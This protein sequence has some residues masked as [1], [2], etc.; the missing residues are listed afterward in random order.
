M[1]ARAGTA[2]LCATGPRGRVRRRLSWSARCV[3]G[4]SRLAP[5]F[6]RDNRPQHQHSAGELRHGRGAGI[7]SAVRRL[8]CDRAATR[9]GRGDVGAH[10]RCA[11]CA[12]RQ[13]PC[14]RPEPCGA[15]LGR[16]QAPRR[17]DPARWSGG[18]DGRDPLHGQIGLVFELPRGV[19]SNSGNCPRARPRPPRSR[20]LQT[21]AHRSRWP[22]AGVVV[23][24]C[25]CGCVERAAPA[26]V[27][28]WGVNSRAAITF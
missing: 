10:A 12:S 21:Q 14:R 6:E 18:I 2:G 23:A 28:S 1:S 11:L 5:Q 26:R 4:A 24:A 7:A 20:A 13:P 3:R 19:A 16:R 27:R 8:R 17:G 25:V 22:C 9:C 15:R